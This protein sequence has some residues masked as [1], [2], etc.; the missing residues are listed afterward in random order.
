MVFDAVS[1]FLEKNETNK[2]GKPSH[3]KDQLF[4]QNKLLISKAEILLNSIWKFNREK[5]LI[6]S[7]ERTNGPKGVLMLIPTQV[8]RQIK[9][10][11]PIMM[12]FAFIF[13]LYDEI[14][15][16]KANNINQIHPSSLK[17]SNK[18]T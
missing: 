2:K 16:A 11:T 6:C 18:Q 7:L 17:L 4:C 1:C 3:I 12:S 9:A 10:K 13:A 14:K 5:M 15:W 8:D